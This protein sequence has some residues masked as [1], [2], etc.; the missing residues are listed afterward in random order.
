MEDCGPKL[1]YIDVCGAYF[2]TVVGLSQM[3]C[4]EN[5]GL[6]GPFSGPKIDREKKKVEK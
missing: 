4:L 5:E 2:F 3:Y 6:F 1:K